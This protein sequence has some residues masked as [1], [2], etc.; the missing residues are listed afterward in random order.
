[1]LLFPG[2]TEPVEDGGVIL[3][4]EERVEAAVAEDPLVRGGAAAYEIVSADP[5]SPTR[6]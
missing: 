1:M 3:A 5:G 6:T 4:R 2:E